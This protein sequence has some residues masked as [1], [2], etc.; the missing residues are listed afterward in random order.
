MADLIS[1]ADVPQAE[2]FDHWRESWLNSRQGVLAPLDVRRLG[3]RPFRARAVRHRLGM[4]E[5][6]RVTAGPSVV[7]RTSGLVKRFDPAQLW[8]SIHLRGRCAHMGTD[9]RVQRTVTSGEMLWSD[10]GAAFSFCAPTPVDILTIALPRSLVMAWGVPIP[11]P[12]ALAI[13]SHDGMA[14]AAGPFLRRIGRAVERGAI[15]END[16]ETGEALLGIARAMLREATPR[17]ASS[18]E[19]LLA[20]VRASIEAELGDPALCPALIARRHSVS[21]RSLHALFEDEP[22]T[23]GRWI[24][25]RRLERVR[26]DLADPDLRGEPIGAIAAR[27]GMLNQSHFTAAFRSEYGV[28]PGDFRRTLATSVCT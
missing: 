7:S 24:R 5:M 26:A 9:G 8:L 3:T 25:H 1:T 23:V 22:F 14:F 10:S 20:E 13:R 2:R 11:E 19:R 28:P 16:V 27:W 21:V 12:G 17:T 4:V 6:M 15:R 18:S